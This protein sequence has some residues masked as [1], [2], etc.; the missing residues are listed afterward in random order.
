MEMSAV[1]R[2]EGCLT[3]FPSNPLPL[4]F[5]LSL[6]LSPQC[7]RVVVTSCDCAVR[8]EYSGAYKI[9]SAAL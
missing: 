9:P 1:L 3:L 8:L 7:W 5:L 2:N 4:L 6:S